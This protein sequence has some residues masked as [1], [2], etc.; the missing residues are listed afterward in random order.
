MS[1]PHDDA[2]KVSARKQHGCRAVEVG[3]PTG[4]LDPVTQRGL[5]IR[6]EVDG[7]LQPTRRKPEAMQLTFNR[8]L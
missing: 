7:R 5:R 2:L 3:E 6:F 8:Y 1:Q 4:L